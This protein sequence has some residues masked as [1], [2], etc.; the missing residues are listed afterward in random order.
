[1]IGVI[2]NVAAIVVFGILGKLVF[3]KIFS[4]HSDAIN[5]VLGL[6]IAFIGIRGGMKSEDTGVLII[7]LV[8]GCLIGEAVDIEG[9][10][11]STGARLENI[12][13]LKGSNI[14]K[15]FISASL[16]FCVGSM[17]II[18]PL[19]SGLTGNN[20]L[21]IVKSILDAVIA[22]ILAASRGIGV[23]LAAIPVFVYM[24]AIAIGASALS[25][26]LT[27][28]VVTEISAIGS[29]ML[30]AIGINFMGTKLQIKAANLIP[31][32]IMPWVIIEIKDIVLSLIP[33]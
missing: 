19:E 11:T 2:Y 31:S 17:A 26:V 13:F 10:V 12:P 9:K 22:I 6:V 7:S 29:I 16:I 30:I 4:P 21:L 8:I 14:G 18:G 3:F 20:E 25:T 24:G 15:G 27:D 33:L 28:D 32:L 23:V 5:R 1:M